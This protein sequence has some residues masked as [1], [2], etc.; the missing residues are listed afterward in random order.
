MQGRAVTEDLG[1]VAA[2]AE[3]AG[4]ITMVDLVLVSLATDREQRRFFQPDLVRLEL[5]SHLVVA[6][7]GLDQQTAA[8]QLLDQLVVKVEVS[9]AAVV[10]RE[11][12]LPAMVPVVLLPAFPERVEVAEEEDTTAQAVREVVAQGEREDA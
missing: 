5:L 10:G 9:E 11:E 3:R 6:E 4:F 12:T 2:V 7:G 1:A 8:I